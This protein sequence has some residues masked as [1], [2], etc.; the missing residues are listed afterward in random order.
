[1]SKWTTWRIEYR[2]PGNEW[3]KTIDEV[4][5]QDPDAIADDIAEEYAL[6]NAHK[7]DAGMGAY[8]AVRAEER[9]HEPHKTLSRD[10]VSELAL[11]LWAAIRDTNSNEVGWEI[12]ERYLDLARLE[13]QR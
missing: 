8:R 3:F 4:S 7:R 1:M 11:G 2:A 12:C 6:Y 13:G 5:T 9:I 10:E